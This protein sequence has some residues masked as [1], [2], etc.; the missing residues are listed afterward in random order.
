MKRKI[1]TITAMAASLFIGTAMASAQSGNQMKSGSTTKSGSMSGSGAVMVGGAPMYPSRTIAQNASKA[2]NL[3]TLVTAVKA[4]GLVDTLAGKGPFTVF[5]PTN[6]AFDKLP[7]GTVK[8]VLKPSN[9]SKLTTILTYHVVPGRLT[10]ADLMQK[11]RKN[12]GPVNLKTVEGET[13]TVRMDDGHLVL[14]DRKGGGADITTPD[15]MQ[16]NGVVHVIDSVL[17]P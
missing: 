17:M 12:G 15:V 1:F 11:I 6:K 10:A 9:K 4:A 14:I 16:S 5:A 8:A 7:K 2:R 13:L 3:T